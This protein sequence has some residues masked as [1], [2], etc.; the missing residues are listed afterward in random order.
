VD[1]I[2]SF[3]VLGRRRGLS[4]KESFFSTKHEKPNWFL[5]LQTIAL[6]S[7]TRYLPRT[8]CKAFSKNKVLLHP[9]SVATLPELPLRRI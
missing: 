1:I 5:K 3:F 8:N 6:T 4:Q 9:S 2:V 7:A